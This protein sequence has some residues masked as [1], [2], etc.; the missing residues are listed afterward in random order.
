MYRSMGT[1]LSCTV[2]GSAVTI[3]TVRSVGELKCDSEAL[4]VTTLDA[5]D[6]QRRYIQGAKDTG[7]VSIEGFYAYGNAGHAALRALYASGAAVPFTVT[8]PDASTCTFTAFVKSYAVGAAEV[9]KP[10]NFACTLR[11]SGGF[12]FAGGTA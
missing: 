3:G 2:Q 8:F 1:T 9:D 5:Q 11:P 10:V 4:D 7:E 12:T 6:G